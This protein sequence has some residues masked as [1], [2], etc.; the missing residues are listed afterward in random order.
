M[1]VADVADGKHRSCISS[2]MA[3]PAYGKYRTKSQRTNT[4]PEDMK[5]SC[6]DHQ[7]IAGPMRT[8][9]KMHTWAIRDDCMMGG[10][11]EKG[12]GGA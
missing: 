9:R 8:K 12:G 1:S 10:E 3:E 11:R 6:R 2:E 5:V 7:I 4:M